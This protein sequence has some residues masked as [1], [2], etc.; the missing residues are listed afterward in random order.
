MGLSPGFTVLIILPAFL[1]HTSG[2]YIAS[3]V[4]SLQHV[5]GEY[6]LV[7]PISVDAEGRFLSHAVSAGRMAGGQSRR[8]RKREVGVGNDEWEGPKG[9]P[10]A[11]RERLYYNVTIFGREFHLRLRHNARLVAPGAKM[12]WHDDSDSAQ[13]SEPLHDECLYVGDITD[14]PGA[15]VAISNCDG[16]AGMIKM[17][18]E[19]F[20]IEPVERGD[21]VIEEEE[22]EGGGGRTHVVYRSSAVKKAPISSKAADY[23]SRGADL[24][25]L[26]D[27]ESLYRGVEQS[28]NHT[29]AGRMRRQS[30]DRAYNIEVLLG[31]D[32]SVVQ[33]HGKEHVQM[34]L[35]TL[36]NIVNEIYHDQSLGAKINVVLVR[37]IMLCQGKSMSLI[38]LGNPS[39]SLENVCRW[40]FLQQKQDTGDTEYHDHAIFLTRQE[41]GPT[42]MQGYAPV[43]GMCHPVRS[44]T[45]NHEDGFSSAFV[46]AHETGHVLGMEHDGQGNRCGDEVHMGSIMAPLVQAAFHRFHWSR[47]SM[48]ELGRYLSSYDCLRDDPFHHNWPSLPQ[49][50]GLHYTMNEQCRFD[51]GVGYTMCNA[52]R[53]FDPCK[54]LWCSH[55]DN[56]F[57]CKTKKGPPIDG[58]SCGNGKHCFK[59]HCIWLTP[60]IIKQDGNWGSW[61]EFGQ[62]SHTCGGGVQFRKRKCDN[63]RP[64]NGGRTCMGRTNQFQMCNTNECEDIYSDTREEQCHA[65]APRLEIQSNP[66]QWLPYEH[67]DPEKRCHLYC[68]SKETR[69]VVLIQEMVL[70]GTRCS[71]KDPHS[72]CVQ[73]ECEKVG[74]DGVVGSSKQEDKCGVCGGDNSSCKT[75]KDTITRTAKKHG[76]LKVL[77]IPRGARHLL[78]QELKAT[79]HTLAVKNMASGQFFLNG[80]NDYPESHSV[81]E[82]GVEWEYENDHGKETLQTTGPLRHGILIMMQLYGDEDVNLTYKYMMNMDSDSAIQNN[83]LVEDSAY[84]WAPKRWSYCSKPCGGGKQ[85]L[86]Y[87]CRRKVESK[88]VH[89]S[90]CNKSNMKPRGDTRDCNQKPCPPPIWVTGEWQNCSK[91][92]GKTGMQIRSV[93]CIQPS[94]DNTTRSIRNKHCNDD[95]PETRRPCNR[96]PCPTQWRVGPWSRCSVT[97]GNGTQQRQALCHTRD[98]TIGLCLDS[99]PDTI[100]VCRMDPCPK[101]S[102]DLNK[103]GNILIQWLSRPNP[104][105]PKISSRQRCHGD[106]SVFC[107]MEALKRYCSLP[108]YRRMC[109]K[110]C[111]N[112]TMPEPLPKS[113]STST[114]ITS[115]LPSVTAP[116]PTS[117]LSPGFTSFQPIPAVITTI[118]A[119]TINRWTATIST[120]AVPH[121][122]P[123]P[124]S[125]TQM[126]TTHPR[127]ATSAPALLTT[128]PMATTSLIST[129]PSVTAHPLPL[130]AP[131]INEYTDPQLQTTISSPTT[132]GMTITH[133][134]ATTSQTMTN[135]IDSRTKTDN[136]VRSKPKKILPKKKPQKVIQPKI[137]PK[138]NTALKTTTRKDLSTN[139]NSNKKTK[140]APK[141]NAPEKTTLKKMAKPNTTPKKTTPK[142]TTPQSSIPPNTTPKKTTPAKTTPKKTT[143]ANATPKKTTPA[144]TTP[145]KTPPKKT[146]LNKTLLV[147]TTPEKKPIPMPKKEAP[148]KANPK[149]KIQPKTK[150]TKQT[151][152]KTNL[153]KNPKP[154]LKSATNSQVKVNQNKAKI[155][156]TNPKKKKIQTVS[157]YY[158]TASTPNTSP[159]QLREY[160]SST[161]SSSTS[162]YATGAGMPLPESR[163]NVTYINNSTATTDETPLWYHDASAT[164]PGT[165]GDAITPTGTTHFEELN[166]PSGTSSGDVT[167]TVGTILSGDDSTTSYN[168]AGIVSDTIVLDDSF[169]MVIPTINGEDVKDLA[170]SPWLDLS[171]YIPVR[172]PVPTTT[173]DPA[174]DSHS[175]TFT[176]TTEKTAISTITRPQQRPEEIS[177]NNSIDVIYNRIIGV[178]N[179]ISHNNLIPKR[180]VNLRERTKNKR[181]QELLEEKRNFLLR[182]KRGHAL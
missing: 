15:T 139:I 83:M 30:L 6:G 74:C 117:T 163:I 116:L 34:Y 59:G 73:G 53:T 168:D 51:F 77:E 148:P 111:S 109:C 179:D 100:R 162:V 49:L 141:K 174:T 14:T 81:I 65:W 140:I 36:M 39:Q 62:C 181:I 1:L 137:N 48:Q 121:S 155:K 58:T 177:E 166:M 57:F 102:S 50:P 119:S 16:L 161:I 33:F 91:P 44:C 134:T 24:G 68:Q 64:A 3:S 160:L 122:T 165:F 71:Y 21:G 101:G 180:R 164:R 28:I 175:T 152:T 19:E 31:V 89:K 99:K 69:N 54:Q 75:F 42:G 149:K 123:S 145:R 22:E 157:P 132:S 2:L 95:R 120:T 125:V 7:R 129:S 146:T 96:H 112:V 47:C 87:G 159:E 114:P 130:P 76:F 107:R 93:S 124:L 70:D 103:N 38:E 9:E 106:R 172:I 105:F 170:S 17:E 67:K 55:P 113:Y 80:E 98:N 56:P 23:H 86:R 82:K 35:L 142:K 143:L 118:A 169:T 4:D 26:M 92:C 20:F 104:N 151:Q 90:Y 5:L 13:H 108:E 153:Q 32:D 88:M 176:L 150:V 40:A 72:V 171:E 138:K 182:M 110:S 12:E 94:D 133:L 97:C 45:L 52:Y 173:S 154:G 29:R 37:I 25:G 127:A 8:R 126:I 167:V 11:F 115:I 66:Q 156:K 41:F 84:E 43:T 10:A 61:S 158:T 178:D 18:K 46:V 136:P 131:D 60:D 135:P 144:H 85:Y 128:F 78:I 63:P 147:K 79:S 27:L